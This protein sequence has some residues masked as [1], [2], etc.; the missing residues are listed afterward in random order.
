MG[1][2]S[3]TKSEET[4]DSFW[5]MCNIAKAGGS[6]ENEGKRKRNPSKYYQSPYER[7]ATHRKRVK[8]SKINTTL[9]CIHVLCKYCYYLTE[10]NYIVLGMFTS[11]HSIL[12]SSHNMTL[13]HIEGAK[14]FVETLASSKRCAHRTVVN[15]PPLDGYI[16]MPAM[17]HDVLTYKW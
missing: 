3:P 9:F 7:V 10:D 5:T 13:H 11:P 8:K 6:K 1:G 12:A 2:L 14:L 16:C 17:L 15:V 4:F